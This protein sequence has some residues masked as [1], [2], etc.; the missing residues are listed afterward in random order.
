MSAPFRCQVRLQL[1][2]LD[3]G[4]YATR[5]ITCAQFPDEPDEHVLLRFLAHVLF[6][7]ER[8]EDAQ[9]WLDPHRPDLWATDLTGVTTLWIEVGPPPMKRLAKALA[10]SKGVRCVALFAD[11]VEAATFRAA[12]LAERPRHIEN[13]EL[14]LVPQEFLSWLEGI[15]HRS[16]NWSATLTEGTLYLDSDGETNQCIPERLPALA[17]AHRGGVQLHV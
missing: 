10:R 1:S 14:H 15:G 2:D 3:R 4:I 11:P 8:L 17:T 13:L 16:M 12:V 7:D 6:F 9:G 5:V